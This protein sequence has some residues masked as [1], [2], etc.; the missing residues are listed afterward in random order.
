MLVRIHTSDTAWTKRH[1]VRAEVVNGNAT[2]IIEIA[3][4][5]VTRTTFGPKR[6]EMICF[7][8]TQ[9]AKRIPR[10]HFNANAMIPAMHIVSA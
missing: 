5:S 3:D 8:M 1:A 4:A 6:A 9:V 7:D 10:D 2:A